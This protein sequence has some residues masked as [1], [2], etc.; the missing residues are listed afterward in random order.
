MYGTTSK[1]EKESSSRANVTLALHPS[2]CLLN[3]QELQ[4]YSSAVPPVLGHPFDRGRS[5]TAASA[6]LPFGPFLG[7]VFPF[8]QVRNISKRGTLK[9]HDHHHQRKNPRRW[10]FA[11]AE[12]ALTGTPDPGC[13]DPVA[14]TLTIEK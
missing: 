4:L 7:Q 9:Q 13:S 5:V 3:L 6:A 8:F 11:E 14:C 10:I 1:E 12:Q 2:D